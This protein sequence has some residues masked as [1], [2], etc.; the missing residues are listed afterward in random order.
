MPGQ[1]RFYTKN[2]ACLGS[3]RVSKG[4]P[5]ILAFF[6]IRQQ[7]IPAREGIRKLRCGTHVPWMVRTGCG[8][9]VGVNFTAGRSAYWGSKRTKAAML[10]SIPVNTQADSRPSWPTQCTAFLC[11]F[12]GVARRASKRTALFP[13][14]Q[15]I[16]S[17]SVSMPARREFSQQSYSS[18]DRAS[19]AVPHFTGFNLSKSL[20]ACKKRKSCCRLREETCAGNGYR[21]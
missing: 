7:R 18:G 1:R 4:F 9:D 2:L 14:P 8:T 5:P 11:P 13:C 10:N 15:T 21:V 6:G 20:A 3:K 17:W 19:V 16:P 12:K